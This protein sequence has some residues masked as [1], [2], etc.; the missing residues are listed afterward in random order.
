MF[1]TL[2]KFLT[3]VDNDPPYFSGISLRRL[4]LFKGGVD[5]RRILLALALAAGWLIVGVT[6]AS[7]S[8]YCSLDPTLKVGLPVSYSLKV[9]LLGSAVYASG[10]RSTTTFGGG[11][12]VP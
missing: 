6:N 11:V 12:L 8:T 9:N 1:A 10:T 4:N 7:A 5:M 2:Y 3:A